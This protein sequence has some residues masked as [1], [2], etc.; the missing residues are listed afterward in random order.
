MG[1]NGVA[2]CSV[3][4]FLSKID[5]LIFELSSYMLEEIV[6]FQADIAYITNIADDHLDRYK[7]KQDYIDTKFNLIRYHSKKNNFYKKH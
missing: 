7:T 2:F 6:N 3:I 4:P 1:N 5:V